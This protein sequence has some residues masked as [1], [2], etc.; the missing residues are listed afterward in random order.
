MCFVLDIDDYLKYRNYKIKP[1]KKIFIY[2][3]V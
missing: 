1:G 2:N 3:Y